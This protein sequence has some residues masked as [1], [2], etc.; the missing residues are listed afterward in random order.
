MRSDIYS[1]N[2][3]KNGTEGNRTYNDRLVDDVIET[4]SEKQ[5]SA[6]AT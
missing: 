6:V 2:E 1:L 5:E 4:P 3:H